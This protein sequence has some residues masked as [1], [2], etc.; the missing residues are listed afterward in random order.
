MNGLHSLATG[1]G[2]EFLCGDPEQFKPPVCSAPTPDTRDEP[3]TSQLE[4][5]SFLSTRGWSFPELLGQG[6]RF[7]AIKRVHHASG[8]SS[9]SNEADEAE[10]GGIPIIVEGWDDHTL[11]PREM[12]SA[13]WLI[14]NHGAEAIKVRNI[15]TYAETEVQLSDW[16]H[17]ARSTP[18][19]AYNLDSERSYAKD[20]ECPE[21]WKKWLYLGVLP[22]KILPR[23]FGD[24]VTYFPSDLA[25]ESLMCYFGVGDTLTPV[26]KDLCGSVGQNLMCYTENGGSAYWFMTASSDSLAFSRYFRE[27][28]LAIDLENHALTIEQLAKAPFDIYIGEQKLGD[29]VIVPP[30]C[31]HQVVN[32]GGITMKTS[33]SRMTDHGL[34]LALQQELD[35]YRR[36]CRPETYRCKLMLFYAIQALSNALSSEPQ[37]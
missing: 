14:R 28:G 12:F 37:S 30:A 24:L 7:K 3:P 19:D 4:A 21:E 22:E 33:W 32:H 36:V 16:L 6:S 11:W 8:G 29:L 18:G 9:G 5:S 35:I 20:A 15:R 2:E 31:F 13:D 23:R 25:P 1:R 10:M 34:R 17:R 27:Q 26:H